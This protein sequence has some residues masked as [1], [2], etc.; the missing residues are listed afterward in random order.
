M[1]AKKF[2]LP[3]KGISFAIAHWLLS[4]LVLLVAMLLIA[5]ALPTP[6]HNIPVPSGWE[7]F[8]R[9]DGMQYEGIAKLGYEFVNDGRGYNVAF[10]P[11]FPLLIRGGMSVDLT[12][13]AAGTIANSLAF[14]AAAI[15][16]YRWVEERYSSRTANW[17][18]AAFVWCPFSLF[19]SV[20]YTEGC[21]LLCAIAA[22]RAFEN[23]QY[24]RVAFWGALATAVR[25]PSLALIPT[26]LI[27][28]WLEKRPLKAY[29]AIAATPIGLLLYVL[30]CGWRF[31]EPLAFYRAHQGWNPENG[32]EQSWLLMLLQVVL[33]PANV[34]KEGITLVDPWYPL[35]IAAIC[36][37]G[38]LLWRSREKL[39]L[40]RTDYILGALGIIL[41]LVAGS[42]LINLVTVWGGAYLLWASRRKLTPVMLVYALFSFL[43]ILAA[44]R[45]GSAERYVYGIAPVSIA[46]GLLLERYPRWGYM[47]LTFFGLLLLSSSVRFA[48]HLWVG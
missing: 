48:Q 1:T 26:F 24:A 25:L 10:L 29:L 14:L 21:F 17:V 22:L 43:L 42:P 4:R 45:T 3:E 40:A 6:A 23:E 32:W 34:G 9:W 35:G 46:L 19:G 30:Y 47:T 12:P 5:P 13:S 41:W 7:V 15:L 31:G 20:V 39:G 28:A 11:L 27:V 33:G 2:A 44:Q 16:L 36:A 37:V 38:V 8:N 18:T